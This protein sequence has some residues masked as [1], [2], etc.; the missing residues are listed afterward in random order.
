VVLAREASDTVDPTSSCVVHIVNYGRDNVDGAGRRLHPHET[1]GDRARSVNLTLWHGVWGSGG[2]L[3]GRSNR[4]LDDGHANLDHIPIFHGRA[5]FKQDHSCTLP[6]TDTVN[7]LA[8]HR[9]TGP[10]SPPPPPPPASQSPLDRLD[11]LL[12]TLC[13]FTTA[14][15]TLVLGGLGSS[16]R[17]PARSSGLAQTRARRRT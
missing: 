1:T 5:Y 2:L 16:D 12:V 11:I 8:R 9:H 10:A 15:C 14:S 7:P 13:S 6:G 3:H 17:R 4:I